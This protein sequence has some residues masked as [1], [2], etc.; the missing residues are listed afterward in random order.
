M[1]VPSN[2]NEYISYSESV[3]PITQSPVHPLPEPRKSLIESGRA[4]H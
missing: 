3:S 1:D 4:D 2:D